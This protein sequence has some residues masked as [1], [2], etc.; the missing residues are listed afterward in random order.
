M[1]C[2]T[3]S[4][5]VATMKHYVFAA[6]VVVLLAGSAR[7][8]IIIS[9][10][11]PSGSSGTSNSYNADWFELTNTGS[12]AQDITGWKMDDNSHSFALAVS[13]RGVTSIAAGQSVVFIEGNATGT[14]DATLEA[15]FETYWFGGSVPAG[16]IIGAYGGAGVGLSQTADEVNIYNASGTEITGVGFGA[17]ATGVS[18]DNAAGIG[19]STQPDPLISTVSVV[20]VNGAFSSF[21]ANAGQPHEIGS[22][23]VI[24]APTPE[25]GS[26]LL[27]CV[28]AGLLSLSRFVQKRRRGAVE[29]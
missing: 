14:T 3:T 8:S 18:F 20:G 22:P 12:S 1:N 6:S 25:P 11:D 5:M 13:I 15:N 27:L 17:S 28:G 19:S 10:V 7:A 9:E 4:K 21:N 26:A 29:N 24:A 16:F 2:F 23:G